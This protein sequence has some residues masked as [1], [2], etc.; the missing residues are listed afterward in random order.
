M[1]F[2]SAF[3]SLLPPL[4]PLPLPFSPSSLPYLLFHL[5]F[6]LPNHQLSFILQIKV[7]SRSTGN[8]LSGDSFLVHNHSQENGINIQ[9]NEPQDYLP[10]DYVSK[11]KTND[12]KEKKRLF[13]VPLCIGWAEIAFK[14]WDWGTER[15]LS[16]S[17]EDLGFSSQHPR[18][19]SQP[20]CNSSSREIWHPFLASANTAHTWFIFIHV[21]KTLMCIIYEY[22]KTGTQ[23]GINRNVILRESRVNCSPGMNIY[24]RMC[25]GCSMPSG[26]LVQN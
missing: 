1:C 9:Y 14:D 21:G 22:I 6:Y 25:L 16:A 20:L 3:L 19:G 4:H 5:P 7:G 24:C 18:D 11:N 12:Q 13:K 15:W 23:V 8:H 2:C 17:A 10:Q 26:V